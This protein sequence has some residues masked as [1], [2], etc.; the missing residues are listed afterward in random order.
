MFLVLMLVCSTYT[1]TDPCFMYKSQM[2][3][4]PD[5]DHCMVTALKAAITLHIANPNWTVKDV[6][7][8]PME[9]T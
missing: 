9:E 1:P 8:L 5:T 6:I 4:Q 3:G 7:C 2:Y